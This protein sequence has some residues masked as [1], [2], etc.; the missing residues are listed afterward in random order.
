MA[1]SAAMA[2]ALY[3]RL[4]QRIE[5]LERSLLP[6]VQPTHVNLSQAEV[7]LTSAFLVLTVAEL[8]EYFEAQCLDV[9][10]R[11]E[12]A[13]KNAGRVSQA[14]RA[15]ILFRHVKGDGAFDKP[16]ETFF[17]GAFRISVRAQMIKSIQKEFENALDSSLKAYRAKVSNNNGAHNLRKL[18]FPIGICENKVD[19]ILFGNLDALASAR[20]KVAHTSVVNA[21]NV[22]PHPSIVQKQ[23]GGI[24]TDL[25]KLD[26]LLT[27]LS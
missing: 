17:S 27:A 13:W 25:M 21:A 8:E 2:S 10:D 19:A 7:D 1:S 18:L 16:R 3:L 5:V 4:K 22:I 23:V 11:A 14:A 15:M 20:G 9:A 26:R 24:L 12:T 6:S